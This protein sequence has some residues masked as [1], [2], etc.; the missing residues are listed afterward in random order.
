MHVSVRTSRIIEFKDDIE[1]QR[2]FGQVPGCQY[3]SVPKHPE[4]WVFID[5]EHV[6]RDNYKWARGYQY[7]SNF[8]W[9][10]NKHT[11]NFHYILTIIIDENWFLRLIVSCPS[12]SRS[13]SY[14]C[15]GF[16][17]RNVVGHSERG[18]GREKGYSNLGR[19]PRLL[20]FSGCPV[21][22]SR[23]EFTTAY[24]FTWQ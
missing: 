6:L 12:V 9:K 20:F 1:I 8:L 13:L 18:A 4:N 17:A 21:P 11:Y 24:A 3:R 16:S 10:K 22:Q 5:W 23:L 15:G 7:S 14:Y 2:K 19:C